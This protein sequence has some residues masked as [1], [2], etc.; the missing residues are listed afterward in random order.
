MFTSQVLLELGPDTAPPES[1]NS[2]GADSTISSIPEEKSATHQSHPANLNQSNTSSNH[3]DQSN[4]MNHSRPMNG[5]NH[6]HPP[7]QMNHSHQNN[8]SHPMNHSRQMNHSNPMIRSTNQFDPR[9][10]NQNQRPD[11]YYRNHSQP[12]QRPVSADMK[13]VAAGYHYLEHGPRP[14]NNGPV[15][16]NYYHPMP[17]DPGRGKMAGP[18]N[19]Q[20]QYQHPARQPSKENGIGRPGE[21]NRYVQQYLPT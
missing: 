9:L 8:H 12:N 5:M 16:R 6:P 20:H 19:T 4:Q 13:F 17:V 10:R 14:V 21:R 3:S 2:Y 7:H 1:E 15:M 11:Q 18:Y